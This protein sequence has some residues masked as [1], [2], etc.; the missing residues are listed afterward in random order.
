MDEYSACLDV[1]SSFTILSFDL[2][3]HRIVFFT[4]SFINIV[5]D[6]LH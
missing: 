6:L 1:S 3:Q 2:Y 5:L 4:L